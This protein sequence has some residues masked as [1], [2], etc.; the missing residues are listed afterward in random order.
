[1]TQALLS[2]NTL[3]IVLFCSITSSIITSLLTL[4]LSFRHHQTMALQSHC[5]DWNGIR[6]KRVTHT[7]RPTVD[8]RDSSN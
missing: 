7:Q 1:M 2:T 6:V 8:P 5:T 3:A 4:F